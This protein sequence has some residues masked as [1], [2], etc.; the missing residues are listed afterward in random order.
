MSGC[1][2]AKQEQ[3][4]GAR[5]AAAPRRGQPSSG[6]C[7]GMCMHGSRDRCK[8][9]EQHRQHNETTP[10]KPCRSAALGLA[11]AAAALWTALLMHR[12]RCLPPS[13]PDPMLCRHLTPPSLLCTHS[14]LQPHSTNATDRVTLHPWQRMWDQQL[15]SKTGARQRIPQ[16]REAQQVQPTGHPTKL[17]P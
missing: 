10:R 14:R 5:A 7:S 1:V 16:A 9:T 15:A 17:A 3:W 11:P 13:Q 8:G 2:G 4:G 12:G 6:W